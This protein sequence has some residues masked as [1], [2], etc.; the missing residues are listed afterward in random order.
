MESNRSN[1][2]MSSSGKIK[3]QK[4][5]MKRLK[6]GPKSRSGRGTGKGSETDSSQQT[7]KN[8]LKQ[9]TRGTPQGIPTAKDAN[10][11][12]VLICLI[13]TINVYRPVLKRDKINPKHL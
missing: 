12:N 2:K 8:F 9:R 10:E 13:P 5:I 6:R 4:K 7:I 3:N 11:P 1:G